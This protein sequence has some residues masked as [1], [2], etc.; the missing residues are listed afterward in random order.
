[1]LIC[2]SFVSF[3]IKPVMLRFRF[4]FVIFIF[5]FFYFLIIVVFKS[6][7][8]RFLCW[9]IL[10]LLNVFLSLIFDWAASV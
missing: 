9:H 3:K 4:C 10:F 5:L 8:S 1:M 6:E 2:T 7:M